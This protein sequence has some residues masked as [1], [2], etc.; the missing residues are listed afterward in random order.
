MPAKWAHSGSERGEGERETRETRE[1]QEAE[2]RK[3]EK[4][5]EKQEREE[6]EKQEREVCVR[7]RVCFSLLTSLSA[8]HNIPRADEHGWSNGK[9]QKG[10]AAVW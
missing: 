5:G 4:E 6:G 3:R 9:E 8:S 7:V 1:G 10:N 2:E